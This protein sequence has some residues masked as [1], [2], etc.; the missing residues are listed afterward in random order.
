MVHQKS[1]QGILVLVAVCLLAGCGAPPAEQA[2][3]MAGDEAAA[4]GEGAR[5]L[6]IPGQD[7]PPGHPPLDASAPAGGLVW[8]LPEGWEVQEPA[9]RMRIAQYRVPGPAGDAE[10]IVFYFGAGQGGDP[11]ANARRWA[12]QFTLPDGRPAEETMKIEELASTSVPTRIVEVKG[13]YDGGMTMTAAPAEK[14]DGYMLLGGIA[15]GPD[16]PWFFKLT[17]PEETVSGQREAFVG[18]MRSIRPEE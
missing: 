12:G 6:A 11:L 16:A 2:E 14:K 5:T 8:D 7:L 18:L 9:T 15:E 13:T 17:G 3:G 10:C 4:A 1:R